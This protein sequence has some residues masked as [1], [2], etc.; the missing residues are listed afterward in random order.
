VAKFLDEAGITVVAV[1][2]SKGGIYNDKGVNPVKTLE[3]KKKTGL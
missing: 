1:S 3:D 2:D